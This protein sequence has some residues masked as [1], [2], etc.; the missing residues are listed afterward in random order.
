MI[1]ANRLQVDCRCASGGLTGFFM[2]WRLTLAA[3]LL[4]VA[5]ACAPAAAATLAKDTVWSGS[6][7]LTE[8]V[9]IPQGVTLTIKA[10]TS[11]TVVPAE[12]TKTD[13]EYLSPLTEITVR[14]TLKVEGSAT[15]P[16]QFIGEKPAAP[17]SWA[18][19]IV[20]GGRAVLTSCSISDADSALMVLSGS[21][22][23]ERCSFRGNRYALVAQGTGSHIRLT[24]S[25]VRENDYGQ[26]LINKGRIDSSDS[27]IASNRKHDRFEWADA[28]P[29]RTQAI[30]SPAVRP[31]GRVYRDEALLGET[32][33]QGRIEIGGLVR[34]PEGARLVVM[35]GTVVEF[36]R[37]DTNGDGLGEN[38][39][40]I[41][42]VL[43]AKG[44]AAEPIYFRSAER[45]PQPADWDAINIMNSDGVQNII[46]NCQIED[47][48]RGL[49][50]HF[51]NVL[52]NR[53]LFRNSYRGIQ[54]QESLAEIRETSF[55]GSKSAVQGRD[56][57]IAFTGNLVQ[58]NLRGVNFYR[59]EVRIERNRFA[60]SSLDGL[61]LRDSAG[62]VER[63][64][65]VGNRFGL[66][67]QDAP[68]GRYVG[69]V[70]A[71]NA[72][73]GF[74]LKN[75]DNLELSGN[76]V[77]GNGINGASLQDVRGVIRSN[78]FT[79]N[80]ERGIGVISFDGA[81]TGNNFAANGLYAIDLEGKQDL[82]APGNWWGGGPPGEVVFD[83]DDQ[84]GRGRVQTGQQSPAP[85]PFVWPLTEVPTGALWRGI[86]DVEGIVSV[87]EG[88]TLA[89]APGTGVRFA[90]NAGLTVRGRLH[91]KGERKRR[92]SFSSLGEQRPSAWGEILLEYAM[93]SV[94]EH[95]DIT[96]ATWGIHSHFTDLSLS[97]SRLT[98]NYGGIRF[99]S[100]PVTISRSL[101]RGNAIGIRSYRGNA[102]IT[103]NLLA[104]NETGIFVREKGGGLD[105]IQNDLA[106][107]SSYA[108]R[109]GDFNDEDV[110]ASGNW[111]GP[112]SPAEAI[113]DGN[114][115]EGIGYVRYEPVLSAP[116]RFLLEE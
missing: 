17:G 73:L 32:V 113:F 25:T 89:I 75:L 63:N 20:D 39:I 65:F 76:F 46:E 36:R 27:I 68:F 4:A 29:P 6:V 83:R 91:A 40:M 99:R 103:G 18:G 93:G 101:F 78:S 35:P 52:V 105:I 100:G 72:E 86:V 80:G 43:L 111:W 107:N 110:R 37:R 66:M 21:A 51:S 44:T 45:S 96:S 58:G 97:D 54:F 9:L 11:I 71:G 114:Q 95:C 112:G 8:D 102:R 10:G 3:V 64:S 62:V 15:A 48:Y 28:T 57:E 92:I 50:F 55:T 12:S 84:A 104:G 60:G 22:S 42:G 30:R 26:L 88:I 70:A 49:H 56:S 47:A 81:I 59:S 23:A 98:G 61:R 34:V 77:S 67:S 7:S 115:E 14:G 79:D 2:G 5:C 24:G 90:D 19:L 31:V 33:W 108:V 109:V 74:S 69:N 38:G 116:P 106:G 1:S 53:S 82:L 87:P 41:Q 94:L 85:V 13:P 16:V